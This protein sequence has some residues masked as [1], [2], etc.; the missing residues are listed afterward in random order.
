[1]LGYVPDQRHHPAITYLRYGI[2]VVLGA[3]DPATFGYN[4]FTLDWYEAFMAWGL[5]LGD[6]RHLATN[7]LQYSSLSASEK[8]TAMAKWKIAWDIFITETKSKAC[9]HT[10]Q[11]LT[12]IVF[13]I[14]PKEGHINGDTKI[15]KL[16]FAKQS[17]VDLAAN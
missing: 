9:M 2:P 4:E 12:P 11:N 5:Y 13:R 8:I 17:F 6:R 15:F 16:Q 1:M 7:S 10:F 14:F 3:D